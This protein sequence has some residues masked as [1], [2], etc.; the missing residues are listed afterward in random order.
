MP[1]KNNNQP[2][3]PVNV[4]SKTIS[5]KILNSPKVKDQV[6]TNNKDIGIQKRKDVGI[7]KIKY[8]NI[9]KNKISTYLKIKL[10]TYLRIIIS[11]HQSLSSFL[12]KKSIQEIL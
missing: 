3:V 5:K 6:L 2:S 12:S 1:S 4:T 8:V 7:P 10:S 9:P 11:N